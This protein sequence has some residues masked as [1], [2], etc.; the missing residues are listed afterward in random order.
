MKHLHE[1][2]YVGGQISA[3]DFPSFKEAGVT[4]IINNRPDG[5]E[6]NQLTSSDAAKLASEHA[7]AYHY[8]PMVNGQPLPT[9]LVEDFKTLL[10]GNEGN[11][12]VH[13]RSGM[14]SSFI[15]ALGQIPQG[16]ISVDEA[17][18]KAQAAGIPL[19]NAR[20]ALENCIV[21]N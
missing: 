18:E 11:I 10:E 7:I 4:M 9:T 15:W 12:L 1:N 3:D 19:N 5:E 8:L 2:I 6:S 16:S 20:A 21:Q 13:C 14:R 17:I